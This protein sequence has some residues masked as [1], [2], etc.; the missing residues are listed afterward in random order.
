MEK[1][2]SLGPR[3]LQA[4]QVGLGGRRGGGGG[5]EEGEEEEESEEKGAWQVISSFFQIMA[6]NKKCPGNG[7]QL[8]SISG[9]AAGAVLASLSR[10]Q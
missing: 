6:C 1:G 2:E 4:A 7:K 10:G 3:K 8:E 9:R 5:G